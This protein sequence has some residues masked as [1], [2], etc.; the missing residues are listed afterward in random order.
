MSRRSSYM[1]LLATRIGGS[2]FGSIWLQFG[3]LNASRMQ[4]SAWYMACSHAHRTSGMSAEPKASDILAVHPWEVLSYVANTT[5]WRRI[6]GINRSTKVNIDVCGLEESAG[7]QSDC[8]NSGWWW[9]KQ[10]K[11]A[12]PCA[13]FNVKSGAGSHWLNPGAG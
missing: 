13:R 9:Q 6:D 11:K 7:V 12:S 8:D 2:M 10:V 3:A 4:I 5:F 1:R